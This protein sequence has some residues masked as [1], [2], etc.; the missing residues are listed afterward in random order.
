M[1]ER[2]LALLD[3]SE[4]AERA[5]SAARYL[6]RRLDATV[7]L[8]SVVPDRAL[9]DERA[10]YL[11]RV[12]PRDVRTEVCVDVDG[13]PATAIDRA[14][15]HLTNTVPSIANHGSRLRELFDR[16]VTTDL[17]RR[18]SSP[19]LVAG[20]AFDETRI[21]R[22]VVVCVDDDQAT[23]ALIAHGVE[24]AEQLREGCTVVTVA[25][26][27]PPPLVAGPVHRAFGPDTE[28][29]KDFLE[30]LVAPYRERGHH[31]DTRP[32]FDPVGPV[33]GLSHYLFMQPTR[34]VITG[35]RLHA[36][37][38]RAV[39]GRTAAGVLRESTVPALAVPLA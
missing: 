4:F 13:D 26:S 37:K 14:L 3:G 28:D 39:L 34:L 9:L 36:I 31:V 1:I 33:S 38:G 30:Q 35:S 19:L 7:A 29:V 22:D 20:R 15:D 5:A 2:F 23:S 8:Y 18:R 25:E 10:D 24:W 6:A 12:M 16:S 27:L 32:I 21:G 17:L 11:R